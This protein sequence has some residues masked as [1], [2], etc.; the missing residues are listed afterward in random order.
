MTTENHPYLDGI[1]P[2][3]LIVYFAH[4]HPLSFF[5]A[6]GLLCRYDAEHLLRFA[7]AD[8]REARA[9]RMAPE[10]AIATFDSLGDLLPTALRVAAE[11]MEQ[12]ADEAERRAAEEE[13]PYD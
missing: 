2:A 3:D 10:F 7:A 5:S 6:L 12:R 13:G 4:G 8:E 1:T 11:A 9:R